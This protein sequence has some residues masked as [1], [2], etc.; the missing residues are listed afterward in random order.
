MRI[1]GIDP[2]YD[3]L[4]IAVLEK[5]PKQKECLLY[6]HCCQTKKTDPFSKRLAQVGDTLNDVMEKWKPDACAVELLYLFKNQKTAMRVAEARGVVLYVSGIHNVPVLEYTPL[7][8]KEAVAGN[9][10]ADKQN[11]A[12]ILE[13]TLN[14]PKKTRLDDEYDAIATALTCLFY[15]KYNTK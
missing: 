9:G 13:K 4:G 7:Q 14:L 8:I 3:R 15:K 1:I 12:N 2:G 11:I 10:R 5:N 6:S